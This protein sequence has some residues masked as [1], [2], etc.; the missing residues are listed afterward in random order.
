MFWFLFDGFFSS[1]SAS[2]HNSDNLYQM[3]S[4]LECMT[5]NQMNLGSTLKG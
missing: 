3:T 2:F 5:W 4:Q 1:N